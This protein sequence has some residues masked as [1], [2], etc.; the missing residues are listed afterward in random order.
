MAKYCAAKNVEYTE[1]LLTN[2]ELMQTVYD[3]M[4][5]FAKESKLNSLEKPK[6]L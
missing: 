1:E 6:Q 4:M 2:A 5:E 3:D